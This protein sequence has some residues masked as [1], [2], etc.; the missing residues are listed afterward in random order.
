MINRRSAYIMMSIVI[1][2]VF[3]NLVDAV[4]H[5]DYFLKIPI[6]ILFFLGLPMVFFLANKAEFREFRRLFAFKKGGILK[7]LLLG[8]AIYAVI[9]LGYFLTRDLIDFSNVTSNLTKSMG[10]TANNFIYVSLYISLMNSFL[11]EF[12]FR[13]YGF[14]T[15]K[16][17]T[18][19]KFAYGFSALIFAVYHVGM[20]AGMFRAGALCLLLLGLMAGGCIFNYLNELTG[21]IYPSWFVHMFAN[22]AINTVGFILFGI[23]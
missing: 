4:V 17:Y 11:E 14:I 21:T 13:G 2:S 22:F 18:S 10:I 3:V 16:N 5:P 6:K 12:F 7:P 19:R 9:V 8:A 20:L 23:L 15:L 1:F